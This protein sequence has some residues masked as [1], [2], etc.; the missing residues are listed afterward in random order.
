MEYNQIAENLM[1]K[2]NENRYC[3]QTNFKWEYARGYQK[4]FQNTHFSPD[5]VHLSKGNVFKGY[6]TNYQ[7]HR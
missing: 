3:F 7:E 4:K 1:R 5:V 2:H 6:L